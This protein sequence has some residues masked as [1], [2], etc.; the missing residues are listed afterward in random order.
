MLLITFPSMI[1]IP[2]IV[3]ARHV[4]KYVGDL[5]ITQFVEDLSKTMLSNSSWD[6][7]WRRKGTV[8]D[9]QTGDIMIFA[10]KD[11][12]VWYAIGDAVLLYNG[13]EEDYSDC[14][15]MAGDEWK[16]CYHFTDF[17]LYSKYVS[18]SQMETKLSNF[19]PERQRVIRLEPDD[20]V[21]LLSMTAKQ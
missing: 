15:R 19:M 9:L 17:R 11:N 1:E 5:G 8:T 13:I 16:C 10:F 14:K 20:Y 21:R 7:H 12:D 3:I 18:Y 2:K 4:P 6:R